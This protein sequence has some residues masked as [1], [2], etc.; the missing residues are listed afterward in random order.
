MALFFLK[1]MIKYPKQLYVVAKSQGK[2]VA[3]LGFFHVYE[4]GKAAF[5]KKRET[6]IKWAYNNY[7]NIYDFEFV[8]RHGQWCAK[9]FRS[10]R[11]PNSQWGTI[12]VAV[13]E[14]VEYQPVVWDNE[15]LAG[16]KIEKSVSR[17]S[18][19]N[20]LWRILDPH[21]VE[22]EVSTD[23]MEDI[24]D[25]ATITKGLIENRC[26]WTKAKVLEVFD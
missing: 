11:D 2:G 21:G 5:E 4:P 16:F 26:V 1:N 14:P 8:E 24:I 17:Y 15:P 20:K 22:F 6:Q 25:T 23:V 7:S 10:E 9:G 3:P 12:K 13:C 18:T 19:S